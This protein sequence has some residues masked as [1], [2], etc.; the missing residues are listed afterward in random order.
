MGHREHNVSYNIEVSL[1][2]RSMGVLFLLIVF[3][4][5]FFSY[6]CV[7]KV[8]GQVSMDELE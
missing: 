1:E 8:E 2:K 5:V 3:A 4:F 7:E 6:I